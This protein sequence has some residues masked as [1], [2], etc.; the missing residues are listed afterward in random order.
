LLAGDPATEAD[1][2]AAVAAVRD[3]IEEDPSLDVHVPDFAARSGVSASTFSRLFQE[4]TGTTPVDFTRRQRIRRAR[5][6]LRSTD[7]PVSRVAELV[8]Y[9]DPLYFSRVFRA[10]SGASPTAY[11]A[12]AA[13][14]Q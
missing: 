14:G 4:L 7:L 9:A 13:R 10:V 6:L 5:R 11:R 2:R 12:R 3:S 8:G 1:P